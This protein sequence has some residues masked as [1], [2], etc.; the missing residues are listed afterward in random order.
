[1]SKLTSLIATW[2]SILKLNQ[3]GYALIHFGL[4]MIPAISMLLIIF[5]HGVNVPY[6][7]EF[8]NPFRVLIL[9]YTHQ[10]T[11]SELLR[12]FNDS[13]KL[14]SNVIFIVFLRIFGYWN[15][16]FQL[17]FTWFVGLTNVILLSILTTRTAQ[18]NH[19]SYRW[20]EPLILVSMSV[21]IFSFTAYYRWLWGITLH[22]IIPD[23]CVVLSAVVITLDYRNITK[24]L[25]LAACA[26]IALFSF[27]GGII[28]SLIN[29]GLLV[30]L[31]KIKKVHILTYF[32]IVGIAIFH[33]LDGYVIRSGSTTTSYSFS[34][35]SEDFSFVMKFLGNPFSRQPE[36]AFIIGFSIFT[37]FFICIII[38][39]FYPSLNAL[40]TNKNFRKKLI[41]WIAIGH[42][43]VLCGALTAYFRAGT[44]LVSPLDLRYILHAN[45]L[46]I[47]LLG[48]MLVWIT[49]HNENL[50]TLFHLG[51]LSKIFSKKNERIQVIF[52]Y[53]FIITYLILG[54]FFMHCNLKIYPDIHLHKYKL[55]YGK[56]C[57]QL[58]V[59]LEDKTCLSSIF[60]NPA[61][62]QFSE[63]LRKLRELQILRPG[64]LNISS[65]HH[66]QVSTADAPMALGKLEHIQH[67][68]DDKL[69]ITGFALLPNPLRPADAI[70]VVDSERSQAT[71]KLVIVTIGKSGLPR[72]DLRQ[73]FG[74]CHQ[75]AGWTVEMATT[76]QS[77]AKFEFF[78]FDAEKNHFFRFEHK[79]SFR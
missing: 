17:Y 12:Q 32:F 69:R 15:I 56:S 38:G 48:I 30:S 8:S 18:R 78:A 72:S 20:L 2:Q 22:R 71:D 39:F 77:L 28:V 4:I 75:S 46:T 44:D 33:F 5:H 9:D 35:F 67:L 55:L 23:F 43:S 37:V 13:R 26:T 76:A 11:S 1:M 70:V 58:N 24:S 54:L 74:S 34:K 57:L 14:I 50:Y 7:D 19:A 66:F 79:Q 49:H 73:H 29:L 10:L 52:I 42:Y 40:T 64:I 68:D 59:Y 62:P 41:P 27:S 53:L 61:M 16:K 36:S 60:P 31:E 51:E 21:I 6:Y 45:Y 25:A 3:F 65:Y 63:K 47:A